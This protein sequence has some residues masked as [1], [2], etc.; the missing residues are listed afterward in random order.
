MAKKSLMRLHGL[1]KTDH[2]DRIREIDEPR[3]AWVSLMLLKGQVCRKLS[4]TA[5]KVK[6]NKCL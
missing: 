4:A 2:V 6:K 5:R 3:G 1:R